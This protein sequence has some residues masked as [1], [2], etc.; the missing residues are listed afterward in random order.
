MANINLIISD[1]YIHEILS[2]IGYP[3]IKLEDLAELD[4]TAK[5][6]VADPDKVIKN[7]K[8]LILWPSVRE[9]FKWFPIPYMQEFAAE[10]SFTLDFPTPETFTVL[11]VRLNTAGFGVRDSV[12]PFVNNSVYRAVNNTSSYG[13]GMWGTPYDYD[14]RQAR[15]YD[16]MERQSLI[17]TNK[18]VRFDIDEQNRQITG[19]S[20]IMGKLVIT[21]GLYS[22]DFSKIPLNR[23]DEVIM[24][25][26][27]NLLDHLGNIRGMQ[28]SNTP[29]TFNYQLFLE[30][31]KEYRSRVMDKWQS[32]TKVIIGRG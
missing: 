30:K 13:G 6:G 3:I 25:S 31:A 22:E 8:E 7:L 24:L 15:L 12:N 9:F 1:N 19:F 17:D 21:W 27:A 20:N 5:N 14:M 16:R 23:I 28:V 2:S 10:D 32:M 29:N 11:D 4:E 26:K 18:A